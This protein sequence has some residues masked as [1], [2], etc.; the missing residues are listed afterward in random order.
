MNTVQLPMLPVNYNGL[1]TT[2]VTYQPTYNTSDS[3]LSKRAKITFIVIFLLAIFVGIG[4]IGSIFNLTGE[5]SKS[6][7][8]N[9]FYILHNPIYQKYFPL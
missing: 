1:T 3:C 8:E 4:A 6:M 2:I 9:G 7:N 5:A